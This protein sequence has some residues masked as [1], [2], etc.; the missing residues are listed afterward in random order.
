[1]TSRATKCHGRFPNWG[2]P[3]FS[4][5]IRQMPGNLLHCP[6]FPPHAINILIIFP[7]A[8][9]Q[10]DRQL[11]RCKWPT[12]LGTRGFGLNWLEL[13]QP[14]GAVDS[15][16]LTY[17]WKALKISQLQRQ[18]GYELGNWRYEQLSATL[19]S[20]SPEDT[21]L[22]KMTRRIMRTEDP[23]PPLLPGSLAYSDL[24]QAEAPD[25][26][27]ESQFQPVSV[28]PAQADAVEHDQ[29]R[30]FFGVNIFT[31]SS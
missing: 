26:N 31:F 18:I 5:I 23:N 9:D 28:A 1:M 22:W 16:G 25:S 11:I 14:S 6:Q 4:S 15:T 19:E 27:V 2:F 20:F 17:I 21:L 8:T 13:P 3:G 7:S 10:R 12:S 30:V 24:E 29:S